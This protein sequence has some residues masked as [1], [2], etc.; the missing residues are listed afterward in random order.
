MRQKQL[1]DYVAY[2]VKVPSNESDPVSVSDALSRKD[3]SKWKTAMEEEINSLDENKTWSLVNLPPERKAVK[4]KWV[5]KIKRDQDGNIVRNKARLVAVLNGTEL[6]IKKRIC[7]WFDIHRYAFWWHWP[8][9][10][11]YKSIKWMR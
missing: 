8:S 3:A 6:I 5:F 10:I 9:R 2:V 1:T 4:S 11:I 7:Q